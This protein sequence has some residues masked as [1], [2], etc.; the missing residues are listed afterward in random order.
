VYRA[1]K[2][3]EDA[4]K[5]FTMTRDERLQKLL[6]GTVKV[7]QGYNIV[8]VG[9]AVPSSVVCIGTAVAARAINHMSSCM[10]SRQRKLREKPI[11]SLDKAVVPLASR[12]NDHITTN[13]N[14][15]NNKQQTT[16]QT[17]TPGT[18]QRTCASTA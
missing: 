10:M 15:S 12:N 8:C 9:S 4:K 2:F 7:Q 17:T 16:K 11:L 14:T 5:F 1:K 3:A 18:P 6:P 13:S